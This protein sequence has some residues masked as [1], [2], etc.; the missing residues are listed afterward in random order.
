M[1]ALALRNKRIKEKKNKFNDLVLI[2]F[3]LKL[4]KNSNYSKPSI[5]VQYMG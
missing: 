2:N 4:K 5:C 3:L 1:L